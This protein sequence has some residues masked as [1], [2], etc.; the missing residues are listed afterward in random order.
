MPNN[1]IALNNAL[2]KMAFIP[3]K[4]KNGITGRIAP[5]AK[6]KNEVIAAS[7]ADP[8]KSSILMPNSSF[9]KISWA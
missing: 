3:P 1:P 2:I 8:F 6:S 4:K 7:I 5:I 9:T